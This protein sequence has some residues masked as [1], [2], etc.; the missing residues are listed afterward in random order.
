MAA[1]VV[2]ANLPRDASEAL[3]KAGQVGVEKGEFF[4]RSFFFF[5]LGGF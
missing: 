4:L 5:S 3:E 1:S 2:L